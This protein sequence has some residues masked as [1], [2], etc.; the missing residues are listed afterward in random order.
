MAKKPQAT[1]WP[2]SKP[3]PAGLG[4]GKDGRPNLINTDRAKGGGGSGGGKG[5][6]GSGLTP[7]EDL[8]GKLVVQRRHVD[9]VEHQIRWRWLLDSFE[10]GDRYR[11]AVYGPDRRGLPARNLFRHKREYPDPQMNPQ[12]YQGFAGF[13]AS[14]MTET[15]NIGY[16][17]YPGQL[18]ADAAATAQDDDYEYRRSRTPIP[19]FVAE[20]VEIH[21][22]KVY[23][24]EVIRPGPDAGD[25]V[26]PP[27]LKPPPGGL[28]LGTPSVRPGQQKTARPAPAKVAATGAAGNAIT[29]TTSSLGMQAVVPVP[30][31]IPG[32]PVNPEDK[33]PPGNPPE[34]IEWWQDVDGRGTPVDDWMR[35]TIAP[36]LLVLGCLDVVLDHPKAPPGEK[37]ATRADELR[38]GL[39]RCVASYILPENMVWWR[40][41][42]AGRYLECLIREYIDPSDRDDRGQDGKVIDPEDPGNTGE[43]WRRNFLRWRLWRPDESILFSYNGDEV[44]ERVPHSFG[45]V[46]IVRLVDQPRHRTP[47]LGKSRYDAIAEYQREYYNRDSELILSDTLQAHPF[48]SGPEDYCKA[49]NTLSVGPGYLLPKKKNTESGNYEGFEY[50]SPP[51]DPAES[52][53][54]NKEDIVDMKDRRAGLCKPAGASGGGKGTTVSQSGVSKQLDAVAGHKMLVSIAKSLAKAE[55]LI[56][57]YALVVLRNRPL[58]RELREQIK[59]VYPARFELFAAAEM[60][61]GLLKLQQALS[62]SGEAPETEREI[63]QTIVR[64]T[65]VGLSDDAYERL[66]SEIDLMVR[67]KSQLRE[68]MA[69]IGPA[70]FTSRDEA[71]QGDGSEEQAA[72]EDPTGVSGGTMVSNMIPSVM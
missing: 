70:G 11:N 13:T 62:S 52:L 19:E 23:D 30:Q 8:E 71:M 29:P 9:W 26:G 58:E 5:G 39:D 27:I 15:A 20:A 59:V 12:S 16:G 4:T 3:T 61:D 34:L 38:L 60:I 32:G 65:L 31:P 54:R 22:S 46:P 37:I 18:G 2:V 68:R 10:G 14:P 21:L 53:R 41:D 72:G 44:L 45:C 57:E 1:A 40:L 48:L 55:R 67:C 69:E 6:S 64:Q 17:P 35:D 47:H 51:K 28:D 42:T 7:A 50:V 36:L 24:Q 25:D 63:L 49:D 43:V 66:D 33:K 56:A